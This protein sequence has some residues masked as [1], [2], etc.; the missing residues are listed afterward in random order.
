MGQLRGGRGGGAQWASLALGAGRDHD[1]RGRRLGGAGVSGRADRAAGA[2]GDVPQRGFPV[3]AMTRLLV[4][5]GPNGSGKSSL[6]DLNLAADAVKVVA[7]LIR[8]REAYVWL[9]TG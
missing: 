8:L 6:R 9:F 1:V 3:S 4:Y 7:D 2:G 5:A